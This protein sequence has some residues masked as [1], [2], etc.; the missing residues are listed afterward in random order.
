MLPEKHRLRK[1]KDIERV[2]AKGKSVFDSVCGAR[3]RKGEAP[4][5]R[6]AIVVGTKI[7][8]SAV[9]RNRLR[10]RIREIIHAKLSSIAPGFDVVML[11]RPDAKNATFKDLEKRVLL[12][13]RKARL[14]S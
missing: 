10:R 13:L 12:V 2:F 4:Q 9:V 6:F 5:T 8:K 11:V 1:K 7:S 3:L 14:L